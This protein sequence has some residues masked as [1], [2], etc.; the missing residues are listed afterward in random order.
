M[1]K[2]GNSKL[3]KSCAIFDLPTSVCTH[4]CPGCY[5]KKAERIYPNVRAFREKN[6]A[7][8]CRPLEFAAAMIEEIA[9]N[10]K[11]IKSFRIHSSGD[12]YNRDYI[13][14]WSAIIRRFPGIRFYAYTKATHL[15]FSPLRKLPNFN[16]IS[17]I[18]AD[19]GYNYG[20][21]DRID[22][23]QSQ[24]YFLCPDTVQDNG[25]GF[26]MSGCTACLTKTK[27]CFKIH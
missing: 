13:L 11:K 3:H 17:S 8:T 1:I 5:A 25:K 14:A 4:S 16:L 27:V 12:F 24:G 9:K 7:A 19:G 2:L 23:L 6:L 21:Q 15:D 20:N 26:C 10:E 22:H 18:A